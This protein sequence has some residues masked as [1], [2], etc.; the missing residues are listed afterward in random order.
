MKVYKPKEFGRMIGRSTQT[1]QRWDREGILTA[2]RT[3]TNRRYY[4][5]DQ[6]LQVIGAP[7]RKRDVI[8]YCRVSSSGQQNDL[9]RQ[10][11]ALERFCIES[12]R[13]ISERLCDIGSSLD[14]K[15]K[16]FLKLME[17][18]EQGEVAEIVVAHQDRLVRFGFDW[19]EH[20]CKQ[21]GTDIVV[22][23]AESLS[24]VTELTQD[25]FVIIQNF[26][27]RLHGLQ[28]HKK[29]IH[30]LIQEATS[31]EDELTS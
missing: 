30:H 3:K 15:R 7:P 23:N 1:L 5:Y 24:P 17:R 12:G 13:A 8:V 9:A 11:K 10:K 26:S 6:Y 25:L 19:F 20:F 27:A 4:T 21:H 2:Y 14:Y 18:V 28:R 16:N 29:E 31:L 22:I